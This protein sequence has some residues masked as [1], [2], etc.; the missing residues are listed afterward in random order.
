MSTPY[1]TSIAVQN[2][3]QKTLKVSFS[4]QLTAYIAAMSE[5][6]DQLASYP[7]YT[8]TETTR[9]YDGSGLSSVLID[10]VHAITEVLVDG[11][12]ATPLQVPYN[13]DT[14]TALKLRDD[15][16]APSDANISV[17][18]KHSLRPVLD[19]QVA[20]ACT[21]FVAVILNQV[22]DQK[23]GVKSEKI[24]E[25]SVTFASEQMRS[26]YQQAKEIIQSYRPISF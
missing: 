26:D 14:K 6:C 2:Y 7:I 21:V 12:P 19:D 3:L 20:F 4:S 15:I 9:L 11:V 22:K 13:S 16:F 10:P 25:Y 18:G 17:T 5:Y 1:T 23:E 24:G 8:N